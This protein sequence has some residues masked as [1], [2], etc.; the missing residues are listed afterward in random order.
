M[1]SFHRER[2]RERDTDT[3]TD[4]QTH[5]HRH[6]DTHRHTHTHTYSLS[7]SP[8]LS[9]PFHSLNLQCGHPP[10]A[11]VCCS[12]VPRASTP[13]SLSML[14]RLPS[15]SS[16]VT[17]PRPRGCWTKH[18]LQTALRSS[19]WSPRACTHICCSCACHAHCPASQLQLR[20]FACHAPVGAAAAP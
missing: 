16:R 10:H 5:T 8:S 18:P 14:L 3:H 7:I 4:T 9:L 13:P 12:R 20:A 15:A 19:S 17:C 2:D 11:C 1:I 6:T